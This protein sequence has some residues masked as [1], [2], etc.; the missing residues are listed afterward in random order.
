MQAFTNAITRAI[1]DG[2]AKAVEKVIPSNIPWEKENW[3]IEEVAKRL[4][5]SPEYVR[6][7]IASLPSFPTEIRI[8]A[9]DGHRSA[10]VWKAGEVMAWIDAQRDTLPKAGRP[11]KPV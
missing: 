2:I 6:N 9:R 1:Q 8:I 5:K 10:P 3:G 7:R 4:D 11:R